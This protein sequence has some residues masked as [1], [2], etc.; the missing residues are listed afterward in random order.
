MLLDLRDLVARHQMSIE[1]VI[2]AG[3]HLCEEAEVYEAVGVDRV[4]WIEANQR[5]LQTGRDKAKAAAPNVEH[6]FIG[7]L[8]GE[9]DGDPVT[10]HITNNGQSSS[11]LEFGTHARVSPDVR[12]VDHEQRETTT[13][14]TII[15]GLH[16]DANFLN[17]DLQGAELLVLR[18]A[19]KTLE[20][21]AYIYTEINVDELYLGCARFDELTAFLATRGF[22]LVEHKL[23]GDPVRTMSN[24]VGWGDALYVRR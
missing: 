1:G 22:D 15:G 2:H 23:A 8:L 17:M 10:F 7:S 16:F 14:D 5:I 4:L 20:Q 9:H 18:G 6:W 3:A 19:D 12:F 24:W 13:L 21:L 11:I